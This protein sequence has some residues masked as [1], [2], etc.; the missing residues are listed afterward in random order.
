MG[1]SPGALKGDTMLHADPSESVT[2]DWDPWPLV[3]KVLVSI[4]VLA[5]V[6]QVLV[7]P[8]EPWTGHLRSEYQP[9]EVGTKWL[10]LLT[11]AVAALALWEAKGRREEALSL[12]WVMLAGCMYLFESNFVYTYVQVVVAVPILVYIFSTGLKEKARE[13][14]G[15]RARGP[16]ALLFT[17]GVF[18][19]L[20]FAADIVDDLSRHG[21]SP[22]FLEERFFVVFASFEEVYESLGTLFWGLSASA[23]PPPSVAAIRH[24]S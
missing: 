12:A 5:L 19:G 7:D 24:T 22:S 8:L 13:R 2:H 6:A 17:G 11:F 18:L 20:G 4:G 14:G 15:Q 21:L 3:W 9:H 1:N 16:L 10:L 23:A